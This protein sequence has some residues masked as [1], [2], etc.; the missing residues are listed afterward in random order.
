MIIWRGWGVLALIIM[1]LTA[2]AIE[3]ILEATVGLPNGIKQYRVEHPW[4]WLVSF[5]LA[6]V[7]CWFAGTALE[8]RE[9][10][11]A[12]VVTDKETGQDIR[13]IGR[14]DMFWIPVK[15]WSVVYVVLAIVFVVSGK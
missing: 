5:G 7:F 6:A 9:L 3:G 15:W 12:K 1:A 4:V 14:N 11:N 2:V 10:K 8:R 13:L